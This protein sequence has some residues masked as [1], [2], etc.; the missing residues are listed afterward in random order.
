MTKRQPNRC[1]PVVVA[2]LALQLSFSAYADTAQALLMK[3]N[4]AFSELDYDGVFTFFTGSELTSL[5]VVHKE[6]DGVQVERLV[7]LD[8]APREI[9]R[10]GEDVV[11]IV[12]PGDDIAVLEQ[13]IPAGPF[14]RAF[15]R[16]FAR[17]TDSYRVAHM[18]EGR[19]AGRKAQRLSIEP[20]DEHR[21]GYRLWLDAQTHLLLRSELVD[22]DD[23]RLEIFKFNSV[24]F[25]DDVRALDLETEEPAGSMI[26]HLTLK[27]PQMLDADIPSDSAV[28]WQVEWLPTG[29][30]MASSDTRMKPA[31]GQPVA[32]MVYSDGLATFSL[33]IE[34]MPEQGAA[35]MSVQN[36]ATVAIT[37]PV[38][39]QALASTADHYLA[40]LV[41]EIP[42]ATGQR[43]VDSLRGR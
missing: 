40:T 42:P 18:G 9:I 41:G 20:L 26:S 4:Q 2:A 11:C 6:L 28:H 21:Y 27:S 37:Q 5:R 12:M 3:M 13:S 10:R 17:I 30:S 24:K 34:R 14:A 22:A 31:N 25:G 33:F 35:Q 43:V 32:S 36:G 15:V 16:E 38:P 1:L 19:V 23:Q 29:F 8:G 39:S 7:H